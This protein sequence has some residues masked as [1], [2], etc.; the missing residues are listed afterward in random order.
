MIV[1]FLN[2]RDTKEIARL[3]LEKVFI[4]INE[5]LCQSQKKKFIISYEI[6]P[7]VLK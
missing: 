6:M 5:I 4:K 3:R 2:Q 1:E 7:S